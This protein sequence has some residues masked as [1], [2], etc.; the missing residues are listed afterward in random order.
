MTPVSCWLR[1]HGWRHAVMIVASVIALVPVLYVMSAALSSS[2]S[3]GVTG[4]LPH[5]L[6]LANFTGLFSN[7]TYP[8]GSWLLNSLLVSLLSEFASCLLSL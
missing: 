7:T 8:Y 5:G 6:T 4:L 1:S 2:G 3:L